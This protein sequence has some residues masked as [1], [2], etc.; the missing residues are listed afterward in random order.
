VCIL[1]VLAQVAI[2]SA[3][4]KFDI[5]ISQEIKRIKKDMNVKENGY[6]CFWL[7][8]RKGFNKKHINFKLQCPM[9]YLYYMGIPEFKSKDSTL[10]MSE[11]FNKFE[12][13][14]NRRK[15]KKVEKLIEKYSW[16]LQNSITA[17]VA[18]KD[19]NDYL[20]LRNDFDDMIDD[21]KQTYISNNYLGLMS[22]LVD[23]AFLISPELRSNRNVIDSNIENNKAI[24]LKVLYTINP[25]NL[26]KIFSKNA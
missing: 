5:D 26:L 16:E 17:S 9:N 15:S 21:I 10:P 23:R 8:I 25:K 18:N 13:K 7:N 12:L 24:L 20:L 4:R 6:P 2:D 11:F 22:W 1:S 19:D 3:K 14:E